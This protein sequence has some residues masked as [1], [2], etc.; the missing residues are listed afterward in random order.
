MVNICSKLGPVDTEKQDRILTAQVAG[1][2]ARHARI[3]GSLTAEA[4]AAAVAELAELAA[5]RS[6]LL[7]RFAGMEVGLHEGDLDE[8]RR[9]LAAQLCIEARADESQIPRWIEAQEMLAK[10]RCGRSRTGCT[11]AHLGRRS[12]S[13]AISSCSLCRPAILFAGIVRA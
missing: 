9:V 4:K 2:A 6:D 11:A 3:R 5:G 8:E 10:R 7:A 1:A 12:P 13:E